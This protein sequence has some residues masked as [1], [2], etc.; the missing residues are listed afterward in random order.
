MAQRQ[1]TQLLEQGLG[2]TATAAIRAAAAEGVRAGLNAGTFGCLDIVSLPVSLL[3]PDRNSFRLSCCVAHCHSDNA[4]HALELP[5]TA[6][7][8]VHGCMAAWAKRPDPRSLRHGC[9]PCVRF[10]RWGPGSCQPMKGKEKLALCC[11]LR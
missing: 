9:T 5:H 2:E 6:Q 11:S 7:G 3:I 1:L 8:P 4:P 10:K